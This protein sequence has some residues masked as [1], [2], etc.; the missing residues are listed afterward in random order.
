[1]KA[2]GGRAESAGRAGE[3]RTTPAPAAR[4]AGPTRAHRT[5]ARAAALLAAGLLAGCGGDA[6]GTAPPSGSAPVPGTVPGTSSGP[7]ATP[8]TSTVASGLQVPWGVAPLPDG[9]VLVSERET[10]R[11]LRLAAGKATPVG[12]VPQVR[13]GG[14]GGLLGLAASP[15]GRTVYA[16]LTTAEDNRVVALP[17]S[18]GTLGAPAELLTG[19]PAASN[20]DGGRILLGPDGMLWIGTGDASTGEAA[21]DR[22]SLAGKILRIEPD[23]GIP[24][25]NPFPGSPV[26]SYGH[27]NVQGLAFDS[28]GRLWATEFGQNTWDELNLITKGA[29]Y[30]WPTVEGRAGRAGF[31]DPAVQWGTDEASPSG[32][33]IL[34]VE[35]RDVAYAASL[36]GERL[37][38]VPLDNGTA[39]TPQALL[40]GQFGR[41]RTVLP[42]PGKPGTLWVTTSNTDG[43]GDPGPQDDRILALTAR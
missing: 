42:A 14:E 26:W 38:R 34:G 4:R 15:D 27:R 11:V 1:M 3:A 9:T 13:A 19:I 25:D 23:G 36:R 5:P 35:G 2:S 17:Y 21:Q 7:A 10:G 32:L 30:G 12:T 29:N 31:T 24:A 8:G 39:G 28:G 20:H 22:T 37:W 43:R 40:T 6:T 16:Y 41:L 18:G 33:A